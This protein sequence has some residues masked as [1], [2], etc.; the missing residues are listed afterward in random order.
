M[1]KAFE[2]VVDDLAH[3]PF[4]GALPAGGVAVGA[5]P[6]EHLVECRLWGRPLALPMTV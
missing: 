1:P 6:I 3:E 4:Q 5:A 2:R